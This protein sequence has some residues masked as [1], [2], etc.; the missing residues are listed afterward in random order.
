MKLAFC[1][2][3]YF[4]F[5]G[6]QRDFMNI[7]LECHRRGY[8][9]RVYTLF[10]HGEKPSH[11]DITIVPVNALTNHKRYQKY[12]D[13]VHQSLKEDPVD[14]VIGINKM[15]GLHVYYAG[16]S[17]YED[18]AQNNRQWWY[19]LGNRY[20]HFSNYEKSVFS[21]ASETEILM[22]SRPQKDLFVNYYNTPEKRMHFLPPGISR[23][24]VAPSNAQ[25]IRK[26]FR[27]EFSVKDNEF[28]LL[29]VGSGFKKKGLDRALIAMA[30][31][32]EQLRNNTKLICIGQDN[33]K[34]F[35]KLIAK[36]GLEG[37]ATI[38]A[39]RSDIP[40]FLLGADLLVHPAS[41]ENAG[42]VLV[43]AIV[44]GLPV[45]ATE[46]CGYGCYVEQADAG[47]LVPLPFQQETLNT[48][49][50][51]MLTNH[52][53]RATWK[54]NGIQFASEADIYSLPERAVDL[55]DTVVAKRA[56]QVNR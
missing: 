33:P 43:E 8:S 46:N 30:E 12:T 19:R 27:E 44:A 25:I 14:A 26:E 32:P 42:I 54:K 35:L 3:K 47:S 7:A 53:A 28:L 49:L 20:R 56:L 29:M 36:L 40:R 39:G 52:E 9:I 17:C 45:L 10:W 51:Q 21:P 48:M 34:V 5:G 18:I 15:P 16:D 41:D 2:Y 55:I 1:L 38:L 24:R 22:I 50:A 6:L 4:P 23:D 11:F 37:Q 13:W 31:L